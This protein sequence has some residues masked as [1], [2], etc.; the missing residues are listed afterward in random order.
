MTPPVWNNTIVFPQGTVLSIDSETTVVD[1]Q[2]YIPKIVIAAIYDG[3]QL[4]LLYREQLNEFLILASQ[5]NWTLVGHNIQFDLGVFSQYIKENNYATDIYNL[6][7]NNQVYCTGLLYQLYEVAT[8]GDYN[9]WSL[10]HVAKTLLGEYIEKAPYYMN[11]NIRLSFGDWLDNP[12]MLPEPYIDYLAGD[13]TYTRRIFFEL[14]RLIQEFINHRL[15][16]KDCFG[17]TTVEELTEAWKLYGPLTHHIQLKASIVLA[18]ITRNGLYVDSKRVQQLIAN[19]RTELKRINNILADDYKFYKGSGSSKMVQNYMFQ[20]V[21]TTG[22]D[23]PKTATGLYKADAQTIEDYNLSDYSSFFEL[24]E[25]SKKLDKVLESFLKKLNGNYGLFADDEVTLHPSFTTIK[26]T[27]RTSSHGEINSQQIPRDL[28]GL[29]IRE[30][31]IPSPGNVFF[32][33]DYSMIE[34]VCLAECCHRQFKIPQ[35]TMRD[36]INEGRDLHSMTASMIFNKELHEITKEDR[37]RSKALN[38][39]E[40]TAL[41]PDKMMSLGRN[42]GITF[43]REEA[44]HLIERWKDTYPEMRAFHNAEWSEYARFAKAV[45][46]KFFEDSSRSEQELYEI[47]GRMLR[48]ILSEFNPTST[49]GN[50]YNSETINEGWQAVYD[51]AIDN[52]ISDEY[53]IWLMSKQP[54]CFYTDRL[55]KIF[56]TNYMVTIT[57]RF[58]QTGSFT[59]KRNSIFQGSSADLMKQAMWLIWRAGYKIVN[60][61]HDEVL[62][63]I[64]ISNENNY[65]N[66]YNIL[67]QLMKNGANNIVQTTKL[68]VDGSICDSWSKSSKLVHNADNNVGLWRYNG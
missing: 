12:D 35:T 33:G 41:G 9:K 16:N 45:N 3:T 42:Y 54:N 32:N 40:P 49:S 14:L 1:L 55:L 65:T 4:Y 29:G 64:P 36:Y 37:Q 44:K 47:S 53:T 21:Q 25:K 2:R 60:V 48:K 28:M 17:L 58:R 50:R 34:L 13:V 10:D 20:I 46:K 26:A 7:D 61:V 43:T 57:G 18:E 39:G 67:C 30:C 62:I 19:V 51:W 63:E 5:Y 31:F 11:K 8:K 23:L 24:Y 59:E 22:I 56:V 66:E 52:H 6:V 38:F 27:G 68:D 15:N